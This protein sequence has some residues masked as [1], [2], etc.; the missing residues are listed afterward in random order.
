MVV[1][2]PLVGPELEGPSASPVIGLFACRSSHL[3]ARSSPGNGIDRLPGLRHRVSLWM[4]VWLMVP[5]ITRRGVL[6]HAA[7]ASVGLHWLSRA[8]YPRAAA[9]EAASSTPPRRGSL[10]LGV[11]GYSLRLFSLDAAIGAIQRL[12]LSY[13]SLSN[14]HVPWDALPTRWSSGGRADRMRPP[15]G[16][17]LPLRSGY[18]H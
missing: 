9:W 3:R 6:K 5:P 17:P 15:P 4:D 16:R 18:S 10:K 11:A 12:G 8:S 14:A 1:T 7:L 13:A 2:G